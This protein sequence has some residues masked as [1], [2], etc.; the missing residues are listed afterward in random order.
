MSYP[1]SFFQIVK[2]VAAAKLPAPTVIPSNNLVNTRTTYD[3]IFTTATTGTIKTIVMTFPSGFSLAFVPALIE[4][5]GIGDGLLSVSGT[6]LSYTVS[7][8]VNVPAG[9]IIKLEI[10]R[11]GNSDKWGAY[12]VGVSTQDTLTNVIDGMTPS[13]SFRIKDIKGNDISPSFMVRKTLYDD[14]A[15][16]AHGWDPDASTTSYAIYDSDIAGASDD[17]FVS[18]MIRYGNAVYC[19]GATADT[20]LFVVHCNSAPGDSAVLD[21]IITRLPAHVVTSTVVDS[22]ITVSPFG[23]LQRG[24]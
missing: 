22:S 19:T 8:P 6:T 14:A 7:N 20:G 4:R 11:I 17:E 1:S 16:H 15:G 18:V 12:S 24:H 23:S 21:Y 10:G 5:S 2:P 9:T 13:W 3:I